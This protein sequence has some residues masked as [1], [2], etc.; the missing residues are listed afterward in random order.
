M[1]KI[2]L[3]SL[4]V[5]GRR[6]INQ[7]CAYTCGN[8]ENLY[9]IAVAD[10]M[11]GTNGG[12]IASALTCKAVKEKI[13]SF[14]H[15]EEINLKSIIYEIFTEAQNLIS[16]KKLEEPEIATLGTTLVCLIVDNSRYAW[17]N[18]GDSRL[19][20]ITEEHVELLTSD[21]TLINETFDKEGR[22]TPEEIASQSHVL[23]RSI[24]GGKDQPDLS[25]REY[26]YSMLQGGEL[27][28]SCSDGAILEK[29]SED[30]LWLSRLADNSE[31]LREFLDQIIEYAYSNGST[32]NITVA[33]M[34]CG[35][36]FKNQKPYLSGENK[37]GQEAN[38]N[39][40]RKRKFRKKI[41]KFALISTL[42]ILLVSMLL[43]ANQR[44]G[45]FLLPGERETEKSMLR[46]DT[47]SSD[48]TGSI[49]G[50]SD[51]FEY[52]R[53]G[54]ELLEANQIKQALRMF[55]QARKIDTSDPFLNKKINDLK[56]RLQIGSTIED[57]KKAEVEKEK[58]A[59]KKKKNEI[60]EKKELNPIPNDTPNEPIPQEE[61]SSG[62]GS[63]ATDQSGNKIVNH[64]AGDENAQEECE[65][66][67]QGNAEQTSAQNPGNDSKDTVNKS[68]TTIPS[69][70][71]LPKT[72]I[73]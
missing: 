10:G 55:E 71:T 61:I 17:G 73:K 7:D 68:Q 2:E 3:D 67:S 45:L 11:G 35:Y 24:D 1:I 44:F 8:P 50:N 16:L 43:M 27:F 63:E 22:V 21:H 34:S 19:Y 20:K 28:L 30:H 69:Q 18:I 49:K 59:N 42:S 56:E 70:E 25:P 23:T 46:N 53:K 15:S 26:D 9:V 62:S 66:S 4:S 54:N 37:G 40:S 72:D 14:A 52:I 57:M 12:E 65:K 13:E 32:D 36:V 60:E 31:S 58:E 51:Y 41:V 47:L 5:T 39:S 33:A 64:Q 29:H 6:R 38:L 48:R